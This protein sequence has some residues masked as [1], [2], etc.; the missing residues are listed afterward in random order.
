MYEALNGPDLMFLAKTFYNF[1]ELRQE[2][3]VF[4]RVMAGWHFNTPVSSANQHSCLVMM[5]TSGI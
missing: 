2:P 5:D 1:L 4:S 3:G